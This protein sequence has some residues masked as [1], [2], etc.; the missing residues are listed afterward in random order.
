MSQTRVAVWDPRYKLAASAGYGTVNRTPLQRQVIRT[1]SINGTRNLSVPL[2]R[3][4]MRRGHD[5][6]TKSGLG[7]IS[8]V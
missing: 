5:W 7:S 2:Q 6:C 8:T 1:I 4:T 3:R